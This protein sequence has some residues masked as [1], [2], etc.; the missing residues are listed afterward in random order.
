MVDG[1]E[2]LGIGIL[3]AIGGDGTLRGALTIGER[4]AAGRKIAVI[5]IPKT[6]DNDISLVQQTFGFETAV[7]ETGGDL[8]GAHRGQGGA[9]RH[10]PRE[11]DGPPL[12]LHRRLRA[13][14]TATSISAWFPRCPS[15]SRRFLPAL[16]ARLARR[17]H[18][19][20]VVAEGAGQ[21][22]MATGRRRDA[23]GNVRLGDI[24]AFLRDA[25]KKDFERGASSQ[26][27]VHRPEL[28]DPQ[29]A[30]QRRATRPSAW[31]WRTTPC[32]RR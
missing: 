32:T 3:F 2:R 5:G 24:G 20:V 18:A 27:Q 17:G 9:Q 30:R 10:R 4:S 31:A 15:G 14:A 8:R 7:S 22:L 11:A 29:R 26:P 28:H 13:L 12:R 19:V 25:I 21:D 6:I 1:L 16:R 23:S